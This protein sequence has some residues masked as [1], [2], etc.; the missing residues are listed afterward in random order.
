MLHSVG[1]LMDTSFLRRAVADANEPP[2]GLTAP[3][4][5][6]HSRAYD[7]LRRLLERRASAAR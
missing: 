6:V 7:W 4:V 1:V 2:R 5:L 3:L